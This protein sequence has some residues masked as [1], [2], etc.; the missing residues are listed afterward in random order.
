M[1]GACVETDTEASTDRQT[2]REG[3]EMVAP[4]SIILWRVTRRSGATNGVLETV[5]SLSRQ[6][7]SR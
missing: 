4:A 3:E 5:H 1:F 7:R 6:R 2:N